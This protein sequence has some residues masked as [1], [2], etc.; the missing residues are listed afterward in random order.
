M[1]FV[2][3]FKTDIAFLKYCYIMTVLNGGRKMSNI[4][5]ENVHE[6]LPFHPYISLDSRNF[7]YIPHYHAEFEI[8]R[9][10]S[11]SISI[12]KTECVIFCRQRIFF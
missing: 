7:N 3:N 11:G 6:A 5:F 4:F 9:V 1:R 10:L 2:A 8:V 12:T